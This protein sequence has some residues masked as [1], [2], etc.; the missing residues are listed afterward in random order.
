MDE[1]AGLITK[2][3]TH[4]KPFAYTGLVGVLPRAKVDLDILKEVRAGAAEIA[5]KAGIDFEVDGIGYP[6]Y[7]D[8]DE[9]PSAKSRIRISGFRARQFMN[10][11]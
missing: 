11:P 2:L 6:H 8:K 10:H 4:L 1:I 7:P 9:S 3:L 5:G